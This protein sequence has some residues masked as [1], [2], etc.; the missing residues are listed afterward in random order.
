MDRESL[1][2]IQEIRYFSAA[3]EEGNFTR[4]ATRE[5]CTQSGLSTHIKRLEDI[6]SQRLFERHARGVTAT[7]AGRCLYAS[8]A[9][10]L[11][12]VKRARQRMLDVA[13]NE[14]GA[15][16]I[17]VPLTFGRSILPSAIQMYLHS[18]PFVDV[19]TTEGLSDSIAGLVDAGELE[20]AIVTEPLNTLGLD[21]AS[22]FMDR[23]IL[24][25]GVPVSGHR[26]KPMA[27]STKGRGAPTRPA[28]V[29]KFKLVLASHKQSSRRVIESK[30]RLDTLTS[31][32]ILEVDGLEARLELVRTSEWATIV[33]AF[34][35]AND[36]RA[37]R[38]QARQIPGAEIFL[39]YFLVQRKGVPLR[40]QCRDFLALMIKTLEQIS[41]N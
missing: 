3:Y 26:V 24:V 17:G 11:D 12:S 37:G 20:A 25:T 41:R 16:D 40:T 9:D 10:V 4:A 30:V 8:C 6:L 28:P 35:I 7:P 14:G 27:A 15:I 21:T 31:D 1:R 39:E 13:G 34:A 22:F 5:H 38:L 23:L 2:F 33:P 29:E 36:I 19:R 32:R 18:H